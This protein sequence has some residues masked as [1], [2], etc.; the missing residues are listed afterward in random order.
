MVA[1]GAR[2]QESRSQSLCGT[3]ALPDG[4]V[5]RVGDG[6][7]FTLA[8]G[9]DIRLAGLDLLGPGASDGSDES[10]V[11]ASQASSIA[12]AA[13]R[14]LEALV[15]GETI[16][17]R[18]AAA[19][20]DRYGRMLSYA[21]VPGRTASVAGHLLA[22][23]QARVGPPVGNAACSSELLSQERVARSAKIGLW[24]DPLYAIIAAGNLAALEAGRGRFAVV[25]GRVVSVRA[26][27]GT[28]YAN[29][30]RRWSQ[31]L[32]VTISKRQE[33]MFAGAGRSPQALENR[34]LRVRGY[35]EVRNG[36]RIE[37]GHPEQ[38]E[39]VEAN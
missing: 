29:F 22:M 1:L 23:G 2:A 31:A 21:A 33:R 8:D 14:T 28:I 11:Q 20:T 25:E 15:L 39:F 13:R 9:R 12:A 37:V 17:L 38:I 10:S 3:A 7:S 4:Q 36:P 27:G 5:V 35:I 34:R 30:G 26:S 18:A 32:T 16:T 24:N 6:R 19:G